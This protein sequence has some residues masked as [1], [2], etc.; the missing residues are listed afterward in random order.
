MEDAL[1]L[2]YQQTAFRVQGFEAPI[3]VGKTSIEA[4]QVLLAHG[5]KEWAYMTAYNPL[6]HPLTCAENE[7]R[8]AQ[9]RSELS[10]FVVLEGE[11]QDLAMQWEAEK[12]FF[13]AGIGLQ[14]AKNLAQKFG[15]R[16]IVYGKRN[17]PAQLVETLDFIGNAE[18]ITQHKVAFLCS[19]KF[20]ASSVLKCY[21]WAIAQREA[22]NCVIS[23]FHSQIEKD[24]L[25][26]L[27]K[28]NQPVLLVLARGMKET[29]ATQFR[30]PL[31]QGRLL[32]LSP[33]EKSVK[34]ST[35]QTATIRNKLM[36]DLADV[37]VVG[38]ANPSGQLVET[39]HNTEK[40]VTYL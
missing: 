26:Y 27:L 6:S 9:L 14:A 31:E 23:G 36:I 17:E 28:G 30:K 16:A 19:R 37:I 33:F 3:F 15:Q 11:G 20:S 4:D 8:N 13:V 24:V 5:F 22:G 35:K 7:S 39:L 18:I 12:S 40:P 38:F 10:D 21:D 29:I 25:H 2:T 32:M 1:I 34:R